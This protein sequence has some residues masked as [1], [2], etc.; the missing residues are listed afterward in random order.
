MITQTC[1]DSHIYDCRCFDGWA[2]KKKKKSWNMPE[3]EQKKNVCVFVQ[4]LH[5]A[6]DERKFWPEENFRDTW[7]IFQHREG[8]R[9]DGFGFLPAS[10]PKEASLGREFSHCWAVSGGSWCFAPHAG[11]INTEVCTWLTLRLFQ[12]WKDSSAAVLAEHGLLVLGWGSQITEGKC[13]FS[14]SIWEFYL[15][16][17]WG[18][19]KFP[20]V[21]LMQTDEAFFSWLWREP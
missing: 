13:G 19:Q 9:R 4:S 1:Q 20:T 16:H 6:L 11:L 21:N 7:S 14:F 5:W 17:H 8:I 18:Q 15:S 10:Q 3:G 2:L 12:E